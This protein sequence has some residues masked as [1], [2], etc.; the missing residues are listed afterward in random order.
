MTLKTT[1]ATALSLSLA[2]SFAAAPLFSPA[3]RA[4]DD[5]APNS[6]PNPYATIENLLKLPEGR[7]WGS[8][9]GV[10]IAPNGNIWVAERCGD[11]LCQGSPI[12]PI[13]LFN[14][15]GKSLRAFGAGL[16]VFPHG[17][18]LDRD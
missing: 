18:T 10:A 6:Q 5:P 7:V 15:A 12:D 4:Q 14:S 8:A 3:L 13:V 2:A 9:S 17:L 16:F 11:N 1:R